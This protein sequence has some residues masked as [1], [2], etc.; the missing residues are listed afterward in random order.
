MKLQ[1]IS[2]EILQIQQTLMSTEYLLHLQTKL[3][4]EA[5]AENIY[6]QAT[7]F[8]KHMQHKD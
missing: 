6:K 1:I 5:L 3:P 8:V 7:A 4:V 2:K